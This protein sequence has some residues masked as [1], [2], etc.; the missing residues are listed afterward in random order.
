MLIEYKRSS[1]VG[2][3]CKEARKQGILI[4]EGVCNDL[5]QLTEFHDIVELIIQ[6]EPVLPAVS[7]PPHNPLATI[8]SGGSL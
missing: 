3:L 8:N 5:H 6:P 2:C 7:A 4:P 1:K